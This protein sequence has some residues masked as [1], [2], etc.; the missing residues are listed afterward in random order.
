MS[1]LVFDNKKYRDQPENFGPGPG[2]GITLPIPTQ[3]P[4]FMEKNSKYCEI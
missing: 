2:T 3:D 4:S 1:S